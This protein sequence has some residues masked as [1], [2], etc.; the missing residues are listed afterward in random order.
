MGKRGVPDSDIPESPKGTVTADKPETPA[1]GKKGSVRKSKKDKAS[2]EAAAAERVFLATMDVIKM[3]PQLPGVD[4]KAMLANAVAK[5]GQDK[6]FGK[7]RELGVAEEFLQPLPE[8]TTQDVAP[9]TSADNSLPSVPQP[10]AKVADTADAADTPVGPPVELT[11]SQRAFLEQPA[12]QPTDAQREAVARLTKLGVQPAAPPD[13]IALFGPPGVAIKPGTFTIRDLLAGRVNLRPAAEAPAAPAASPVP[14]PEAAA[15]AT[16]AIQQPARQSELTAD[17]MWN[18]M[19]SEPFVGPTP[20]AGLTEYGPPVNAFDPSIQQSSAMPQVQVR[21]TRIPQ[22]IP[23]PSSMKSIMEGLGMTK[24]PEDNP[25]KLQAQQVDGFESTPASAED[26]VGEIFVNTPRPTIRQMQQA[27]EA[28]A[29]TQP[30]MPQKSMYDKLGMKKPQSYGVY[31]NLPA[32]GKA[33]ATATLI[34]GGMYGLYNALGGGGGGTQQQAPA[35]PEEDPVQA[36]R[37]RL[38]SPLQSR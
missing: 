16:Q 20:L 23:K 10:E 8:A 1:G 15:A 34:G 6:V 3:G 35:Q 32:I 18:L 17:D 38:M 30:A 7:L 36:A 28:E 31:E 24:P 5:Y 37:R 2:K 9:V 14:T 11:P 26:A 13:G 22:A 29:A 12:T 27:V 21:A 4:F 19:G 33:A 25:A